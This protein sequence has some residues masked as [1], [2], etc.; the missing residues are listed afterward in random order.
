MKHYLL[1][2][3]ALLLTTFT[4]GARERISILGDSYST[5]KGFHEPSTNAT[6]YFADQDT[7][8]TDVSRVDQTWWHRLIKE[9]GYLLERNNSFSGSTISMTGYLGEDFTDR[10]FNTRIFDLG[11]PDIILI[12]GSTND[13]WANSPIGEFKYSGITKDDIASYRPALAKLLENAIARYPNVKIYFM[14]WDG[15][16][17]EII[18]SA[19]TICKHY[20]IPM[21][22]VKNIATKNGHPTID[23]MAEISRQ[24]AAFIK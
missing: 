18:S 6:W 16:K 7:I 8:Q 13:S 22:V 10:S 2:A 12:F 1:L 11:S 14:I 24:V 5:F 3:A 23:G 15:N 21:L 20:G 17:P 9:N 4:S 19:E